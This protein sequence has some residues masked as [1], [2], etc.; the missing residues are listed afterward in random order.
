MRARHHSEDLWG[1]W[2][3]GI[4]PDICS[5]SAWSCGC[6]HLSSLDSRSRRMGSATPLCPQACHQHQPVL[7]SPYLPKEHLCLPEVGPAGNDS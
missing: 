6:L 3:G 5:G 7:S 2:P 1:C 4:C